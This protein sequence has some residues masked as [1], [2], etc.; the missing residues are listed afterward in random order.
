LQTQNR[1]LDDL[2]KL[3]NGAAGVA[4]SVRDEAG[5]QVRNRLER[6]FAGLDFVPR[7]EFEAVKEMAAKARAEQE[8]LAARLARLEGKA[9]TRAARATKRPARKAKA[10]RR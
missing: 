7:E 5:S 1:F 3:L 8:K 6:W 4:A 10:K 9:P 2:A